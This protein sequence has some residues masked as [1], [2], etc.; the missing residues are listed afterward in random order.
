MSVYDPL[1]AY[2]AGCD[3]QRVRLSFGEIEAILGRQLPKGAKED[4]RWWDNV[5]L[6][7]AHHVQCRSWMSAGWSTEAVD[8]SR[9]TVQ[10]VR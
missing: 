3:G 8:R 2:L 9:R 10:F 7:N 1:G 5:M 6:K 4:D